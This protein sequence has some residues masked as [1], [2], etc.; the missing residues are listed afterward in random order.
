MIPIE[1]GRGWRTGRYRIVASSAAAKAEWDTF[2]HKLPKAM[3]AA[4][5]RLSEHPLEVRGVRQFPLKGKRN[6]PFWEYE[7][8]GGDRLYY[9]VDLRRQVVVVAVLPHATKSDS[10][11]ER[12]RDRRDAFDAVVATQT[13]EDAAPPA[14]APVLAPRQRRPR[15]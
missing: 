1:P 15:N 10:M 5:E 14:S 11:T 4:Y 2:V 12:V 9:A 7:V 3:K 8:S 6:K 13:Q